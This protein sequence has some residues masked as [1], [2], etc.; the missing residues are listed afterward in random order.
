MQVCALSP[1]PV[2]GVLAWRS[3]EP[4]LTAIVKLTFRLDR[5]GDAALA[6]EQDPL[7]LDRVDPAGNGD[8]LAA[9]SDFVPRK[10]RAEV[11]LV[12]HAHADEPTSMIAARLHVGDLAK[13]FVVRAPEPATRIP[14]TEA[15]LRSGLSRQSGGLR[16]GPSAPWSRARSAR[17]GRPLGQ[18]GLPDGLLDARFDFG[19]FNAAPEDQQLDALAADATI[20]LGGLLRGVPRREVRLPGARPRL[21]VAAAM[22]QGRT[23]RIPREVPLRC[24]TLA[25]DTDRAVC[26]LT[27]RAALPLQVDDGSSFLVVSLTRPGEELAYHEIVPAISRAPV[28]RAFEP[29]GLAPPSAGAARAVAAGSG[30][31]RPATL[32][33]DALLEPEDLEDTDLPTGVL[34]EPRVGLA[35][36]AVTAVTPEDDEDTAPRP[37]MLGR[38]T[39]KMVR[40]AI[41]EAMPFEVAGKLGVL[42]GAGDAVKGDHAAPFRLG[43]GTLRRTSQTPADDGLADDDTISADRPAAVSLEVGAGADVGVV[44]STSRAAPPE[45]DT[46]GQVVAP[47]AEALPFVP[48]PRRDLPPAAGAHRTVPLRASDFPPASRSDRTMALHASDRPP[49]PPSGRT[50]ALDASDLSSGLPFQSPPSRAEP[51]LERTPVARP[52]SSAPPPA[53]TRARSADALTRTLVG[54]RLPA[55]VVPFVGGAPSVPPPSSMPRPDDGALP[56]KVA[57]PSAPPGPPSAA[58]EAPESAP[59]APKQTPRR[60][61]PPPASEVESAPGA[62]ASRLPLQ[63]YAEIKAALWA[64]RRPRS[65]VLEEHGLNELSWRASEEDERAQIER[66]AR[67]GRSD[68]ARAITRALRAAMAR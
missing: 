10:A 13:R 45:R 52:P 19:F 20:S 43:T 11:L 26:T 51:S 50:M 68:H 30:A 39:V 48:A 44:G 22:E 56:F 7:G 60:R 66:E 5:D 24:D 25:I 36:P 41:T 28:S 12:G 46:T 65:E 31:S 63:T 40:G 53:S 64:G 59:L 42:G 37:K 34:G 27:W 23:L 57:S 29:E 4:S 2:V 62:S 54:V 47:P 6:A 58:E 3:P 14:L 35:R 38:R 33:A 8:E 21:F 15:N 32:R 61:V 49:P 67:E 18:Y 16:V 17:A 9:A 1:L 55:E